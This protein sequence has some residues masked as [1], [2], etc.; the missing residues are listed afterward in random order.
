M[1]GGRIKDTR[2]RICLVQ[3]NTL[4]LREA[5]NPAIGNTHVV[6]STPESIF[7]SQN[8]V[9]YDPGT[10]WQHDRE[11]NDDGPLFDHFSGQPL[12][13]ANNFS[14][15]LSSSNMSSI[16]YDTTH[17]PAQQFSHSRIHTMPHNLSCSCSIT[18][19]PLYPCFNTI[20]KPKT[21]SKRPTG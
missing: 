14:L 3:L 7:Q 12:A 17:L 10:I 16:S 9:Q 13:R 8:I 6:Q 18:P 20:P 19:P 4:A 11:V 15:S 1:S 5:M 2:A 21:E